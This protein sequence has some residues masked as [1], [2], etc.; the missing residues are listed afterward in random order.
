M[1]TAE[2]VAVMDTRLLKMSQKIDDLEQFETEARFQIMNLNAQIQALLDAKADVDT[3]R[4]RDLRRIIKVI[5]LTE[6]IAQTM[7]DD[8]G[9]NMR[10]ADGVWPEL[11]V[12]LHRRYGHLQFD[13]KPLWSKPPAPPSETTKALIAESLRRRHSDPE[14]SQQ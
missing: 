7:T 12:E 11:C 14:G 4:H 13:G 8:A 6:M 1:T 9:I 3:D 5:G 10:V 2:T